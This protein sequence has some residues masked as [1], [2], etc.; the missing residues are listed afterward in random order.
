[1]AVYGRYIAGF[2]VSGFVCQLDT[3]CDIFEVM[4]VLDTVLQVVACQEVFVFYDN[5]GFS[6]GLYVA[7][8]Q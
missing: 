3:S 5:D 6:F 4:L 8:I 2:D 1:M 7:V